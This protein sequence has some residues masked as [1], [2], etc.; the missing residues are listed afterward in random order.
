MICE[1]RNAYYMLTYYTHVQCLASGC[2]A[3]GCSS[4]CSPFVHGWW[5]FKYLSFLM[6]QCDRVSQLTSVASKGLMKLH[7]IFRFN[8]HVWNISDLLQ[9]FFFPCTHQGVMKMRRLCLLAED[10][11]AH[12]ARQSKFLGAACIHSLILPC[13]RCI[14]MGMYAQIIDSTM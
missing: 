14:N 9:L 3:W 8:K 4:N 10:V 13:L 5:W 6:F 2:R 12:Q 1:H 11:N 7:E